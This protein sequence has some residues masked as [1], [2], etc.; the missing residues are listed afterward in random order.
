MNGPVNDGDRLSARFESLTMGQKIK[1]WWEDLPRRVREHGPDVMGWG[2]V[3]GIFIWEATNATLGFEQLWHR[4]FILSMIGAVGVQVVFIWLFREMMEAF[5]HKD[6]N[7][8]SDPQIAK[9]A[10]GI[11]LVVISGAVLLMGVWSQL[12]ADTIRRGEHQ[13]ETKDERAAIIKNIR[14]LEGDL[15][16]LPET[17]DIGRDGDM[18]SLRKV[19]N[20]GRQWDLPKLD[21]NPGGDC[22]GDLKPY[23]RSLCNQAA[24][25]RADIL[26]A[27]T[28]IAKRVEITAKLD[29][30][31]AKIVDRVDSE[32]VEHLEQM[33]G[34]FG[35]KDQ[36]ELVGSLLTLFAS[37][38]LLIVAAYANDR[39][40]ER[41]ERQGA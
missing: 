12:A 31:R 15:R 5:R 30:E 16:S 37:A 6:K 2:S 9:G 17:I 29:A 24:D 18:E 34:L 3:L 13:I 41:R 8:E 27:N 19:E 33:A 26:A 10:F 28:A 22:D 39:M 4:G 38:A 25:L 32:G 36:W 20:I 40:M 1:R 21:N 7:G 23:P 11:F 14:T 35:D